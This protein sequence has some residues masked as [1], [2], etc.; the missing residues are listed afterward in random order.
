MTALIR[1]T[2]LFTGVTWFDVNVKTH[3]K[4]PY[5]NC[6]RVSSSAS[7]VFPLNERLLA[8]LSHIIL[9][10]LHILLVF[11]DIVESNMAQSI[12]VS[13]SKR[14]GCDFDLL[15]LHGVDLRHFSRLLE[16]WWKGLT[17]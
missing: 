7:R 1:R 15:Y 13:S 10:R 12:A 17:V 16:M 2:I 8:H 3:D 6:H 9:L 11:F 5:A 14:K 4:F